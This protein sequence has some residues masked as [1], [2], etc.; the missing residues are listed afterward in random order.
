LTRINYCLKR[1]RILGARVYFV[2]R[3]IWG[4]DSACAA[5]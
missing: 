1:R 5:V 4:T 3:A 2:N